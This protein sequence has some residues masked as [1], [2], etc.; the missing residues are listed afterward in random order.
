MKRIFVMLI[1]LLLMMPLLTAC[2]DQEGLQDGYYTAQA[3][4]FSHGWKEYITI[5]VK[6]GSIVSVEYNAENASGFI[7][8][9][10]N[11]Y[12][13]N[14]LQVSGTYPNEYTR[15]YANQLL[16]GQG[17]EGIDALSGATSSH[18]SFQILSQAVLEQARMG[19]SSIA[20][21][22]TEH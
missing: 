16:E 19:D 5:L 3:S 10:D 14:M 12:M 4:E 22:D 15:Y 11:T 1:S 6:G 2:G 21:V 18:G 7:K 8:S 13:Q 9:W 17:E 20:I